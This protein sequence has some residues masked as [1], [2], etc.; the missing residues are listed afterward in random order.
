VKILV[1]TNLYPPHYIGGYE[2]RC[3]VA[4]KALRARGHDVAVLT[5]NHGVTDGA[6]ALN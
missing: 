6:P 2:L 4:V 1:V 3:E 5:S